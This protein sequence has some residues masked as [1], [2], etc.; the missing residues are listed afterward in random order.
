MHVYICAAL[1]VHARENMNER[2]W[3]VYL[4]DFVFV[5]VMTT[6]LFFSRRGLKLTSTACTRTPG[7]G[8]EWGGGYMLYISD[9]HASSTR[10]YTKSH[11]MRWR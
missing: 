6:L 4:C 11:L 9:T 3:M 8:W 7:W 1:P 10:Q 5:Y 2:G